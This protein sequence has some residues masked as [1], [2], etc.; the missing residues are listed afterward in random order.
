LRRE[1]IGLKP[2]HSRRVVR[3]VHAIPVRFRGHRRRFRL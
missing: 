2:A 3:R 1:G